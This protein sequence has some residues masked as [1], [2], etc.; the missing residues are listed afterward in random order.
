MSIASPVVWA[1]F[2]G[3]VL[4]MLAL[5][6]GV[7]HRR[8]HRVSL[9]EAAV[10]SGVWVAL[11]CLFA[12]GMWRV[13]G[14][15][16]ALEFF[17]GYVLEKALSVDNLFVILAI[18]QGFA[19][20]SEAQHKVLV[21]G[22]LGALVMRAILIAA[23]TALLALGTWV[24]FGFGIILVI[25]AVKLLLQKDSPS[26][27]KNGLLERAVRKVLP[28]TDGFRGAAFVV[29]EQ[30]KRFATPLLLA[31]VSIEAADLVFAVDSIPAVFSV[32]RDPFIVFTS[33]IF[34]ILGLRSLFFVLAG[35]LDTFHL[36]RFGLAAV[37]AFVGAKMMFT[38]WVHLPIGVSLGVICSMLLISVL[39]SLKYP[40]KP[41]EAEMAASTVR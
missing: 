8:A 40:R 18:M 25:G 19:V 35:A 16:P 6:L 15:E 36:L 21:W 23:G 12:L 9:R 22:V 2:I 3:F 4:L 31:L 37:L 20:P 41:V 30:G 27:K 17:T 32:T 10:W 13:A 34:A 5:D 24:L 38:N 26:A 14:S 33:N 7:F 28:V 29:T 39:A 1:A 11:S